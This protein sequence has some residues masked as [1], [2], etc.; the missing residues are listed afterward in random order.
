MKSL[1]QA[2]QR[3][4]FFLFGAAAAQKGHETLEQVSIFHVGGR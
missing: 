4:S 3:R 1:R 2:Q